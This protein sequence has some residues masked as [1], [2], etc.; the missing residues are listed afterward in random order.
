[1]LHAPTSKAPQMPPECVLKKD[2]D[3]GTDTGTD[4]ATGTDADTIYRDRYR[5]ISR[6]TNSFA[7]DRGPRTAQPCLGWPAGWLAG[8]PACW[9]S[10][11][12]QAA[13]GRRADRRVYIYIYI[14]VYIYIYTSMPIQPCACKLETKLNRAFE[15]RIN[16]FVSFGGPYRA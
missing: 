14:Y 10:G 2:T 1:M 15:N 9:L 4:I 6:A 3:A 12:L 16:S 8:P 13:V 7:G 5:F 11:W